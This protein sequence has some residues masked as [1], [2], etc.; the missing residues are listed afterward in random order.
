MK[1]KSRKRKPIC[2]LDWLSSFNCE[3]YYT[4]FF[5]TCAN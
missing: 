2:F 5:K 4:V 1:T 3:K